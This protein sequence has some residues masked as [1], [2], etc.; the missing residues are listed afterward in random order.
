L[1]S[2]DGHI[3]NKKNISYGPEVKVGNGKARG[4]IKRNDDGLPTEIGF[5][6]SE[7]AL[8]NLP[9]DLEHTSYLLALPVEKALTPYDHISF[10]WTPHGYEPTTIYDK[11]HFDIY[12]YMVSQSLT[13]QNALG[14]AIKI[15]PEQKFLPP[16]YLSIPAEGVTKMDKYL[17]DG[18]SPGLQDAPFIKP[19]VHGSYDGDIFFHKTMITIEF[20][21]SQTTIMADIPQP[22]TFKKS[23]AYPTRYSVKFD[24]E[25]KEYT[26]ALLD[27]ISK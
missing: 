16:H 12:F 9:D 6:L 14:E 21:L 19:F 8:E 3:D 11:A 20:L 15:Q 18:E 22:E 17:V 27:F 2:W 4:F 24:Q 1:I 5:T 7:D 26:I 25:R 13:N 23:G 10:D